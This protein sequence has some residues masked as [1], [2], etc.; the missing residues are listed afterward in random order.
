MISVQIPYRDLNPR[1]HSVP[2]GGFG[3][4]VTLSLRIG[5]AQVVKSMFYIAAKTVYGV[6]LEVGRRGWQ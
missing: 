6:K 1:L 4:K 3:G 2:N 5:R